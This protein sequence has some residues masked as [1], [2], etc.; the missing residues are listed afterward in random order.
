MFSVQLLRRDRS[1]TSPWPQHGA[2]RLL[3]EDE[4]GGCL[5]EFRLL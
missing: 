5:V 1:F 3:G 4:G 2:V